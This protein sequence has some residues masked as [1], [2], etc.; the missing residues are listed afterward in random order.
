MPRA[1][2]S[3]RSVQLGSRGEPRSKQ[4]RSVVPKSVHTVI[5]CIIYIC[6]HWL[7]TSGSQRT[8]NWER[9]CGWGSG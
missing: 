6:T 1:V 4:C 9:I 3:R 5:R 7:P 8:P 2:F